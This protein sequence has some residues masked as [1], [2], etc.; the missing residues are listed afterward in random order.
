MTKYRTSRLSLPQ[1]GLDMPQGCLIYFEEKERIVDIY[2]LIEY[3]TRMNHA[4]KIQN[5]YIKGLYNFN[6]FGLMGARRSSEAGREI[7]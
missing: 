6:H 1:I 7:K 4:T 5:R 3:T 2:I